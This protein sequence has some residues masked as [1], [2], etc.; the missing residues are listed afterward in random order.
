MLKGVKALCEGSKS[1]GNHH[2]VGNKFFYH[3]N[4]V[5]TVDHIEKTFHLD[6]CGWGGHS[7]TTRT[8]N[9]YKE[10]FSGRGYREIWEIFSSVAGYKNPATT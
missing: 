4:N 10:F 8:L 5:C 1:A 2:R 9:S 3:G 6:S 7:S